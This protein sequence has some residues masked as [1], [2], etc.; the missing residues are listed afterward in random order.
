MIDLKDYSPMTDLVVTTSQYWGMRRYG[1][2]KAS[3]LECFFLIELFS[4][5]QSV[6]TSVIHGWK[7]NKISRFLVAGLQAI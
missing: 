1:K 4:N 5:I 7:G 2:Q 3:F 6:F